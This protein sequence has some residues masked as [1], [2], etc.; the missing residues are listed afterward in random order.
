MYYQFSKLKLH[1]QHCSETPL[2]QIS[3]ATLVYALVNSEDGSLLSNFFGKSYVFSLEFISLT[4][5]AINYKMYK[6]SCLHYICFLTESPNYVYPFHNM[7]PANF[8][9]L[10]FSIHFSSKTSFKNI[11]LNQIFCEK[12]IKYVIFIDKLIKKKFC[13]ERIPNKKNY[14]KL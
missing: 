13:K 6:I 8:N 4:P 11:F 5:Y 14:Y 1:L 9:I 2:E 12:H 10:Q 7:F 3:S